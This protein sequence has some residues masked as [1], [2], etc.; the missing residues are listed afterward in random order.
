MVVIHS[1]APV[2]MP[3]IN[4][5]KAVLQ[6]H[7]FGMQGGSALAEILFGGVNP[8]GKLSETFPKQLGDNPAYLNYPGSREVNYGEGIFVGYRYYDHTGVEPLFPFGHGLSYTT[9]EYKKLELPSAFKPGEEV[10]VHLQV[11]NTGKV[12]GKEVVQLYVSDLKSSLVRPPKELKGFQK[13]ALKPGESKTVVFTL[14]ARAFSFYDPHR[15]SWVVEP[16]DFEILVGSS[17]VDIRVKGFIN[18]AE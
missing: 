2:A 18:Y 3:W 6:A 17:S 12:A 8:S 5:V 7:Y 14:D 10:K 15:G 1:G 4:Q 11:K 9:F 16:G 13:V